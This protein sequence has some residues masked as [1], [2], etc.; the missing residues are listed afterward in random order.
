MACDPEPAPPTPAQ[1][2]GDVVASGEDDRATSRKRGGQ[3]ERRK[4]WRVWRRFV[5][6]GRVG[7]GGGGW[8]QWCSER[9]GFY[10]IQPCD[11]VV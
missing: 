3:W 2:D 9:R 4:S 1:T 11:G 5:E 7:G 6:E 8:G 10:I